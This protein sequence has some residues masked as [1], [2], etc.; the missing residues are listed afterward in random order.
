M[1][2][3][4]TKLFYSMFCFFQEEK[5]KAQRRDKKKESKKRKLD[6]FHST[7]D[8]EEAVAEDMAA[9]MGFTGFGGSKK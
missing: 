2:I 5:M 6:E 4:K 1:S 8:N 3:T 9:V 7:N